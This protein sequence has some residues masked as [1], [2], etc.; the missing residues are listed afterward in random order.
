MKVVVIVDFLILLPVVAFMLWL[1]W[2]TAPSD[3]SRGLSRFDP[4][5]AG[6]ACLVAGLVFVVLHGVLD[7]E[8]MDQSIIVVAASYLTFIMAMGACWLVRW[9]LHMLANRRGSAGEAQR[10]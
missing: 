8:G 1:F 2:Y 7:M 3:R 4:L 5:L 10:H 6:L 9:R